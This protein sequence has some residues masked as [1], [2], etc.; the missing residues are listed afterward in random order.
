[1]KAYWIKP[2]SWAGDYGDILLHG[3]SYTAGDGHEAPPGTTVLEACQPHDAVLLPAGSLIC[4]GEVLKQLRDVGIQVSASEVWLETLVKVPLKKWLAAG[5]PR[6]PPG[7]EPETYFIKC[8]LA[9]D[10]VPGFGNDL[11]DLKPDSDVSIAD[12][13]WSIKDRDRPIPI[14]TSNLPSN[15]ELAVGKKKPHS[16]FGPFFCSQRFADVLAKLGSEN[17]ELIEMQTP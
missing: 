13:P 16:S 10:F 3:S 15:F 2:R 6:Y 12:V 8:P 1:M 17:F 4:T 9:D 5:E 7:G 11:Y 14:L